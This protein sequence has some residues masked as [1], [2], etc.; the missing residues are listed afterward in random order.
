MFLIP[1]YTGC[2][3]RYCISIE[4]RYLK[5]K[6]RFEH[7]SRAATVRKETRARKTTTTTT[8]RRFASALIVVSSL[9]VCW[10]EVGEYCF[11]DDSIEP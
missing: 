11:G 9:A 5:Y 2:V 4:K 3:S 6:N 10:A 1:T 7:Y 8:M